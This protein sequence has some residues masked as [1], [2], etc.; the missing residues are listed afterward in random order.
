MENIETILFLAYIY[1]PVVFLIFA[2]VFLLVS[3][4]RKLQKKAAALWLYG[5]LLC[6]FSGT[7]VFL[8]MPMAALIVGFGPGLSD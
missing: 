8:L 1:A 6:L 3:L 2:I 4:I 7:V 5:A